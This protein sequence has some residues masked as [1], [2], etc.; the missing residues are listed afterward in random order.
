MHQIRGTEIGA[1]R[2]EPAR[3]SVSPKVGRAGARTW[4]TRIRRRAE[5][6]R[7]DLAGLARSR[8]GRFWWRR[9]ASWSWTRLSP[10]AP[11]PPNPPPPTNPRSLGSQKFGADGTR[12]CGD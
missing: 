11:A 7:A 8:G 1:A 6:G 2:A 5:V 10:G 9:G 12:R 3:A 4:L